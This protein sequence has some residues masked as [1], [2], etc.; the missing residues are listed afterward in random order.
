MVS[1]G[2]K[3]M[4]RT[5]CADGPGTDRVMHSKSFGIPAGGKADQVQVLVGSAAD[6][7]R[8]G[9]RIVTVDGRSVGVVSV[10]DAFYAVS[11]RCPHMGASMCTGS[12]GGTF[13][14]S[15]PHELVYGMD[16]GVIRCP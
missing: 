9:C 5:R 11:D 13:V 8:E 1:P 16:D 4:A 15:A 3:F 6:I 7:R 14:P 10:G 12:V 2:T